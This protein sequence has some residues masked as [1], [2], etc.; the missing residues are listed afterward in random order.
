MYKVTKW[1]R[2]ARVW[3]GCMYKCTC[4]DEACLMEPRFEFIVRGPSTWA[5]GT[6]MVCVLHNIIVGSLPISLLG[7]V[8][9]GSLDLV[10]NTEVG[11]HCCMVL[12]LWN[13]DLS[14]GVRHLHLCLVGVG[15]R[16]RVYFG[17][18]HLSF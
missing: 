2:G 8:G 12:C 15:F 9:W 7:G 4:C 3:G 17:F 1:I 13:L 10:C 16:H 6:H 14:S 11:I 18:L 5:L